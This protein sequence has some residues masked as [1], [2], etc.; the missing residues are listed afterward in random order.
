MVSALSRLVA[1][2]DTNGGHAL[3]SLVLIGLATVMLWLKI[4]KGDE[5]FVAA[6]TALFYSFRGRGAENHDLG[7]PNNGPNA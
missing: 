6:T 2:I 3:I 4:P 1:I 5:L 7:A